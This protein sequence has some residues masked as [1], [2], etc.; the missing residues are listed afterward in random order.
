MKNSWTIGKRILFGFCAVLAI[1]VAL[2]AFALARVLAIQADTTVITGDCLP[3]VYLVGKIEAEVKEAEMHVRKHLLATDPAAMDQI[4][5]DLAACRDR[6]TQYYAD[7]KKISIAGEDHELFDKM[8]GFRPDYL[9]LRNEVL[10]LSH[11]LKKKE[12]A[13]VADGQ[14]EPLFNNYMLAVRAEV[15]F[16]KRRAGDYAERISAAVNTAKYGLLVGLGLALLIGGAAAFIIIAGANRAL[17]GVVSTIKEGSNQVA[18]AVGQISS[19]SQSLAEGASEQAASLEETSSSLEEMSSMTRRNAENANHAKEVSAQT[20]AAADTGVA[21]MQ[22]MSK[23][24]AEIKGASDDIAKI[25]KTIDEIAFQT[26]ILALNAAVEAARAG[27][28]GMGFAV[29]AEEVRNLAQRSAQAAKETADKIENSIL[30]SQRGTD[31]N[32]KVTVSL[33]QIAVKARKVD[34]IVAEIASASNEQS[35]GI[36][37]VNTAVSQMDK[38]TQSNAASAEE[39]AS[40]AEELSAQANSLKAAVSDLIHLVDGS[41]QEEQISAGAIVPFNGQLQRR[42]R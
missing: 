11:A 38:V 36:N 19:A 9:R 7:Y 23:A 10:E 42:R 31:L 8:Q 35:Q 20:R 27:E 21:D 34:E 13:A 12:A 39:S 30:K 22:E 24:M 40:A 26:N 6:V 33:E 32:A 16:N 17:R 2:G 5:K 4:E 29:V 41:R 15:E 25:I 1:T 18:T 37:Q 3:G 28:A 14:L